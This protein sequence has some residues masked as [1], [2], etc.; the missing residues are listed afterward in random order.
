VSY[1]PK[2]SEDYH[3]ELDF[4]PVV[5]G[6]PRRD[7]RQLRNFVNAHWRDAQNGRSLGS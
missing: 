5:V 6:V 3:R 1:I 7:P 2:D 4:E